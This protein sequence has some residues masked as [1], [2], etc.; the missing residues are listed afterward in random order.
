MVAQAGRDTEVDR[1]AAVSAQVREDT[2]PAGMRV[3]GVE[4]EVIGAANS[5]T[6][7]ASL[8]HRFPEPSKA[9][10]L[11]AFK[12]PRLNAGVCHPPGNL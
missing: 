12:P 4:L 5:T 11:G 6:S 2:G 8:T 1:R 3:A 9:T 7:A 10:P